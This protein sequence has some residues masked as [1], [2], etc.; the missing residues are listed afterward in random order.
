MDKT[1]ALRRVLEIGVS[2]KIED[3]VHLATQ[4]CSRIEKDN[5]EWIWWNI[6]HYVD[7]EREEI[8]QIARVWAIGELKKKIIARLNS[9][10]QFLSE[11]I[12]RLFS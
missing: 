11:T 5:P 6:D 1:Y 2:S 8:A 3:T 10:P 9:D 12:E 7:P 4:V